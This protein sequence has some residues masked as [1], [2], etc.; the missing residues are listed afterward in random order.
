M[1]M[2][3]IAGKEYP[4][5]AVTFNHPNV[6]PVDGEPGSIRELNTSGPGPA[7]KHGLIRL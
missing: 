2:S 7:V 4:F 1:N 3:S 6:D 5:I